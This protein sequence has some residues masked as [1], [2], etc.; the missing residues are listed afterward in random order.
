[1]KK[2]AYVKE[3]RSKGYTVVG[4]LDA[5]GER[6]ALTVEDATYMNIGSPAVGDLISEDTEGA[7]Y[8]SDERYRATLSALRM[9]AYGDNSKKNLT[10]K[11]V[12]KGI[13]PSAA[14]EATRAM[15]ERGYIN[16]DSQIEKLVIREA[17]C[18]LSGPRKIR[19]KLSAKGYSPR[20]IS[21]IIDALVASG[22]IDFK[23]SGDALVAKKL[24]RDA[25]NDEIKQLLYKNGY[26]IC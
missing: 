23:R 4:L 2:I 15:D 19:A 26:N 11:L 21:E 6:S 13:S 12:M 5:D 22:K 3:S 14:E 7:L 16:E 10:R 24:T 20:R 9:L 18:S 17:N 1:M 8:E 25:T